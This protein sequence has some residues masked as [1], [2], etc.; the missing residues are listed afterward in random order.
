[1]RAVPQPTVP[2]WAALVAS[3]RTLPQ[4]HAMLAR[5]M[6]TAALDDQQLDVLVYPT[7]NSAAPLR[8]DDSQSSNC[9]LGATTGMPSIVV[10]MGFTSDPPGLP[11]SLELFGRQWDEGTLIGM[12]G[13][14]RGCRRV[15]ARFNNA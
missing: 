11:L 12:A 3:D 14:R 8:G 10:P 9:D 5:A 4:T 7:V 1:M 13:H 6:A 15:E 2:D